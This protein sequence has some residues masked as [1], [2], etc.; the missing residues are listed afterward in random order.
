MILHMWRIIVIFIP[1]LTLFLCCAFVSSHCD[2][3]HVANHRDFYPMSH[4]ILVLCL[5]QS[6]ACLFLPS[7]HTAPTQKLFFFL[8]SILRKQTKDQILYFCT[9]IPKLYLLNLSTC[10]CKIFLLIS[11][12]S[13]YLY[14]QNLP[15]YALYL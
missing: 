5:C 13:S 6:G 3:A 9:L 11:T 15:T 8:H 1:C 12:K 2:F 14:L 4:V 7:F 10:I